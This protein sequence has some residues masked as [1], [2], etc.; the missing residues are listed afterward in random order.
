MQMIEILLEEME[1]QRFNVQ[2][3][4]KKDIVLMKSKVR[5]ESYQLFGGVPFLEQ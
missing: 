3:G 5:G 1:T 2:V 4:K